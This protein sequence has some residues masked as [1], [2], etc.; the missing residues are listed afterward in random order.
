MIQKTDYL[1]LSH[2]TFHCPLKREKSHFPMA[3]S[4]STLETK[5]IGDEGQ[6]SPMHDGESTKVTSGKSISKRDEK[7]TGESPAVSQVNVGEKTKA[8]MAEVRGKNA[9]KVAEGFR[10]NHR[11][12]LRVNPEEMGEISPDS[13]SLITPVAMAGDLTWLPT[14]AITPP[15]FRVRLG[16]NP[17]RAW[18]AASL[19]RQGFT[20]VLTVTQPPGSLDYQLLDGGA[21]RL[22][23]LKAMGCPAL[24]CRRLPWQGEAYG[25]AQ[26]LRQDE[27]EGLSFYEKARAIRQI[28]SLTGC[29]EDNPG[30]DVITR[31]AA[32]HYYLIPETLTACWIVADVLP[33]DL[34]PAVL[35]TLT[36]SEVQWLVQLLAITEEILANGG[37]GTTAVALFQKRLGTQTVDSKIALQESVLMD[38][39]NAV[40][41]HSHASLPSVRWQLRQAGI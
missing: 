6:V 14:A 30:N 3:N 10:V 24:P 37:N 2:T 41:E 38:Y 16:D 1:M 33:A 22:S 23:L 9:G 25:I 21:T 4:N 36:E 8:T 18:L 40:A 19:R 35:L 31:L 20:G 7:S 5:F 34:P 11:V 28:A 39:V 13:L 17:R 12:N 32:F 27:A 26:Q 29:W 15:P